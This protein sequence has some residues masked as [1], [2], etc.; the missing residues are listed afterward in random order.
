MQHR[1]RRQQRIIAYACLAVLI[2]LTIAV[3]LAGELD[4]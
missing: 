1:T 3:T 2:I 4:A